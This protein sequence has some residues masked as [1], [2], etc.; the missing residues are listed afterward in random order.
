MRPLGL[1]LAALLTLA[2]CSGSPGDAATDTPPAATTDINDASIAGLVGSESFENIDWERRAGRWVIVGDGPAPNGVDIELIQR[3]SSDVHEAITIEPRQLIRT[4]GFE[5]PEDDTHTS[6]VAY[7][8]GPNVFLL[9]ASFGTLFTATR[10]NV[11][12]TLVHELAHVAQW[13]ALTDEY[14]IA[15]QEDEGTQ[16]G[17]ND[18]SALIADWAAATGWRD[19]DQ[20][21]HVTDWVLTTEAPTAYG[22]T[23]PAEDMADSLAL[24][25]SGL[26]NQL[27]S[28]R[29]AFIEEWIGVSVEELGMYKPWVPVGSIEFDNQFAVYNQTSVAAITPREFRHEDPMFFALPPDIPPLDE[30]AAEIDTRLEAR[31]MPGEMTLERDG[32]RWTGVYDMPD[33][34]FMWVELIDDEFLTGDGAILVYVWV[35]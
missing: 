13:Y 21:D 32:L 4:A 30:L 23:A 19:A 8:R 34:S 24:A 9:D 20:R 31:G 7:A 33:G 1:F 11:G 14:L 12:Q 27:S 18:G 29:A 5:V 28:D 25:A 2:A 26:G 35:W 6:I 17:I 10:W 16:F 15:L 22:A 3:A